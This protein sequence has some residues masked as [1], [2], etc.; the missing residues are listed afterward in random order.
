[1]WS[2]R[3]GL[4]NT[5]GDDDPPFARTGARHWAADPGNYLV[6]GPSRFC[7]SA[8]HSCRTARPRLGL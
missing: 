5:G 4:P 6:R 8:I 1:M 2:P 7:I 3:F